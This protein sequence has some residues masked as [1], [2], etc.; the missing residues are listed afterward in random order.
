[1]NEKTRNY[2]AQGWIKILFM[3]MALLMASSLTTYAQEVPPDPP[4]PRT[5]IRGT[6]T[7]CAG[8]PLAGVTV[9]IEGDFD[10][11]VVITGSTGQFFAS[12]ELGS[13]LVTPVPTTGYF[14]SPQ[15]R[16][17]GTT[18]SANFTRYP[19]DNRSNFDGDCRTDVAV[20][21]QSGGLWASLNSS[22]GQVV[23]YNF[24]TVGDI[25]T[26]GDY[27]ADGKTDY[28]VFRPSEGRWYVETDTSTP[29]AFDVYYF[30]V[31]GD[32]P[33][34]RDYDG[35]AKTD[36]ALYRP[37]DRTWYILGSSSGFQAHQ[38]GFNNDFRVTPGDYDGD[39]KDDIAIYRPS[40]GTWHVR[41]SSDGVLTTFQWGVSTDLP[42]QADYDGDGRTDYAVYRGSDQKW[43]VFGS[44]WG[45][46]ELSEW[47]LSTDRLVPGDYSGDGRAD[48]AVQR[49]S[50]GYF[51]IRP[52]ITE[53]W[54]ESPS[55]LNPSDPS[56]FP[57]A[58]AY[59][60]PL[61]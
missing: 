13:Y 49:P 25:A 28:A 57:V 47:G 12:L 35:D 6:I 18:N 51:Y 53:E 59:L 17:T 32:I 3:T 27:N 34:A 15:S 9:N 54:I 23:T 50:N 5:R 7:N 1:M 45:W 39:N 37:S 55:P 52:T 33:V 21:R 61:Y 31:S 29:L 19:R 43:Y 14:F 11:A 4:E 46:T 38:L 10:S 8:I 20:F 44:T 36:V 16:M 56:D 30:G 26:P 2:P 60:T 41:R 48:R 58:A 24:G 42:V 40:D 22:N